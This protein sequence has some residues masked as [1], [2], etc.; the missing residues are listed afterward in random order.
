M[1][2]PNRAESEFLQYSG[3]ESTGVVPPRGLWTATGAK[4]WVSPSKTVEKSVC[5]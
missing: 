3:K 1:L 4:S 2:R 5:A